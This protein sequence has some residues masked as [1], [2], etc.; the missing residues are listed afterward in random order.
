LA[1]KK[2]PGFLHIYAITIDPVDK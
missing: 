2:N 1:K